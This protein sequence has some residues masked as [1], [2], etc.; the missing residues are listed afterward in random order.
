MSRREY[1]YQELYCSVN[2]PCPVHDPDI[3]LLSGPLNLLKFG[4]H[5]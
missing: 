1:D 4:D 5:V 3:M 2:I